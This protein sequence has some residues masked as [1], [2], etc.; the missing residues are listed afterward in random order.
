[1]SLRDVTFFVLPLKYAA[2]RQNNNRLFPALGTE[3]RFRKGHLSGASVFI[4]A[5][6]KG[7]EIS[8]NG[9]AGRTMPPPLNDICSV[10]YNQVIKIS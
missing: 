5:G 7:A 1:M 10:C 4:S 6:R 2:K 3:N 8:G 9:P